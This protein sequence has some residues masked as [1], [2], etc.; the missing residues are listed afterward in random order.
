M[1]EQ[2][3]IK[4]MITQQWIKDEML[5][6]GFGKDVD[7]IYSAVLAYNFF[8]WKPGSFYN[9][10]ELYILKGAPYYSFSQNDLKHINRYVFLDSCYCAYE[11]KHVDNHQALIYAENSVNFARDNP[12]IREGDKKTSYKTHY[13]NKYKGNTAINIYTMAGR[14][15]TTLKEI[16]FVLYIDS[17][18]DIYYDKKYTKN[19]VQWM[20]RIGQNNIL[21]ALENHFLEIEKIIKNEIAPFFNK[22]HKSKSIDDPDRVVPKNRQGNVKI[23]GGRLSNDFYEIIDFIKYMTGFSIPI[24]LL[25]DLDFQFV[26]KYHSNKKEIDSVAEMLNLYKELEKLRDQN[27]LVSNAMTNAMTVRFTTSV[28]INC[29]FMLNPEYPE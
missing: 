7:S 21:K 3:T 14:E 27:I 4:E 2:K 20:K 23:I 28:K 9:N 11:A 1:Q 13:K 29:E 6:S 12:L 19:F 8:G 15:P 25:L 24:T 10:Q 16:A 18:F 26:E 17:V 22:F 5:Y